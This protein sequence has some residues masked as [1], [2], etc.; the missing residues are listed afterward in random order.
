M[1]TPGFDTRSHFA[2]VSE[3]VKAG[4]VENRHFSTF[5]PHPDTFRPTDVSVCM[6]VKSLPEIGCAGLGEVV[7]Q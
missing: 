4:S 5:S 6:R 3:L 7:G 2:T 1:L